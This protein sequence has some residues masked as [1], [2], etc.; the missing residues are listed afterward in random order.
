[1]FDLETNKAIALRL[2]EVF[3]GRRLDLLEDVLHPEFRERGLSAFPPEGR[4]VGPGARRKL[5]EMFYQAIPDARAEVLDVVAEGDKVVIADR[6]G[7]THR[8]EFLGRPGTGDRI[9]W[10]AI[11]I[12][13]IRDGKVL[14]DAVMTDALA[15]VQQ[16]GLVP[17]LT[18]AAE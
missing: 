6:F 3:N 10:M 4:E 8:G 14:E 16:L 1:M 11:H 5:Y 17:S 9:E 2:V 12:Y 13:T 7:G 18:K 15:M